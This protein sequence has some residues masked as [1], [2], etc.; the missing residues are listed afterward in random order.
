MRLRSSQLDAGSGSGSMK[1]WRWSNA[2]TSL[3]AF[4]SSMPL[5]NTS[6]DMSPTPATRDRVGLD[7][8]AHFQ[9]VALDGDPAALR[10][11]AHRLV[12]VAVGAAAGESV[13]EPEVAVERDRVGDVGEGRRALVGRDDEIG[14]VLVVDHDVVGM[15]D[16]VVEDVVGDR[17]QRA[18]EDPVAFRAFRDPGIAVGRA[19]AA[20]WDRSRPSRRSGR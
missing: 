7:V 11:D 1:M 16:L 10:G 3:I 18:D 2:A 19:A 20:A 14:I 6:P 5:P 9:E 15:D 13:A 17:Q 12:V 4:D 8:D